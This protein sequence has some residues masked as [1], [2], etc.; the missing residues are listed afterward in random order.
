MRWCA[1]ASFVTGAGAY[2]A[3]VGLVTMQALRGH[4]IVAP[5]AL[6]LSMGIAIA[7]LALAVSL[8]VLAAGSRRQRVAS[9]H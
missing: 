7:A 5:D 8:G 6:T 3:I 4:S 2:L 9:P 1:E